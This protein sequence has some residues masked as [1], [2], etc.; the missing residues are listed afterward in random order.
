M[1]EST[2]HITPLVRYMTPGWFTTNVFNRA[3]RWLT[4]RGLSVAGSRELAE[5]LSQAGAA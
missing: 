1:T 4:R 2:A 5:A 3:I